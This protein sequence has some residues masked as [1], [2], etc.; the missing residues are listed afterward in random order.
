[1]HYAYQNLS[2][3]FIVT[4]EENENVQHLTNE[5][6]FNIC[7]F[8]YIYSLYCILLFLVSRINKNLR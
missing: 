6:L 3:T 7:M 8:M 4:D 2:P 5:H 1:M